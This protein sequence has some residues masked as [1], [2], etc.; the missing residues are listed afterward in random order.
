MSNITVTELQGHTSGGDANKVK[1]KTG[2][3]LEV[4]GG[5][6]GQLSVNTSSG[7][8]R[9]NV[10]GAVRASSA[11]AD[12]NAGLEGNIF[13]FTGTNA[14]IGHVNG[15]SGS[16]KP[17]EFL[18]AGLTRMTLTSAGYLQKPNQPAFRAGLNTT[19]TATGSEDVIYWTNEQFDIG[20]NWN[21]SRFTAPVS[22]RY[23]FMLTWL[24]VNDSNQ[25]DISLTINGSLSNGQRSRNAAA[26][27]HETTC[28]SVIFNLNANDYVES[29][30][31][32]SGQSI[33]GDASIYWTS[34]QGYLLG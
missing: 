25:N 18:T 32:S 12:F 24:S 34:F 14:R 3:E 5:S 30:I 16:A 17:I 1:I 7:N 21:G 28:I 10:H 29:V 2:H 23:L 9:L 15:A 6:G 11:S 19:R 26:G 27:S 20:N 8:E 13:D 22:G 31:G 4:V 33:Y